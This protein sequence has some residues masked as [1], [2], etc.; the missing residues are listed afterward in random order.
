MYTNAFRYCGICFSCFVNRWPLVGGFLIPMALI[1]LANI[2]IFIAVISQVLNMA[3]EERNEAV[4]PLRIGLSLVV[5]L[6]LTWITG[7][8]VLLHHD[9]AEVIFIIA[10]ALQGLFVFVVYCLRNDDILKK[11]GCVR[12]ASDAATSTHSRGH[13]EGRQTDPGITSAP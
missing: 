4:D 12:T 13:I 1:L 3:K 9:T 6:G 8:L 2:V 11:W 7:Y 10:N 5:L